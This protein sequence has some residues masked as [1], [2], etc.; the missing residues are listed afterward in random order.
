MSTQTINGKTSFNILSLIKLLYYRRKIAALI[1]N[2][3]A[4]NLQIEYYNN[5]TTTKILINVQFSDYMI[6]S[7]DIKSN[8]D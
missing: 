1:F 2:P 5:Y 8:S 3:C 4:P 7:K 6:I